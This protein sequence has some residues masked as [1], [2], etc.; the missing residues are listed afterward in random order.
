MRLEIEISEQEFS[1]IINA[2]DDYKNFMLDKAD[3]TKARPEE[4]S[5]W[6]KRANEIGILREKIDENVQN[7]A[8]EES[9][10]RLNEDEKK[11][12]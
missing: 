4:T 3:F 7:L 12:Y 1:Y 6:N 10:R 2:L 5:A 9:Q 8:F 11:C